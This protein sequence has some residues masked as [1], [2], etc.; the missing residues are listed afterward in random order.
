[1]Q[2][3]L[4]LKKYYKLV[5]LL[6]NNKTQN[7]KELYKITKFS[8]KTLYHWTSQLKKTKNLK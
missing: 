7:V 6:W 3:K 8:V 4:I 1:M 2:L 5:K